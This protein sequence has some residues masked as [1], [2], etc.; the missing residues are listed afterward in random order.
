MKTMYDLAVELRDPDTILIKQID[1]QTD[2]GEVVIMLT[3]EQAGLLIKWIKEAVKES[4][5]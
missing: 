4:Q 3:P 2:C 5:E 1:I